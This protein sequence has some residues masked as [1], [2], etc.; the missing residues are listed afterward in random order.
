[1][2]TDVLDDD[3]D[4]IFGRVSDARAA[5]WLGQIAIQTEELAWSPDVVKARLREAARTIERIVRRPGPSSKAGMWPADMVV[6]WGDRLAM[7]DTGE[8]ARL[9]SARNR[10][11]MGAGDREISRAEQ[12]IGWPAKYL[13]A[14]EHD[15]A[16][17]ALKI[18]MWCEAK[19]EPFERFYAACG[20]SRRTAYRRRDVAFEIICNGVKLDGVLA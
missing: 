17:G 14:P 12:A 4:D 7:L 19:D 9:H 15:A 10:S 16:R 5:R 1:M 8:L 3:D 11:V 13:A 6:E 18:W 2:A 20:C